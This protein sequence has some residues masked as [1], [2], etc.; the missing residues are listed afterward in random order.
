M[1]RALLVTFGLV[2]FAACGP[3]QAGE[4]VAP[5]SDFSTGRIMVKT[6]GIDRLCHVYQPQGKGRL[7]LVI[8]IH[9]STD[10]PATI[11]K[12]TGFDA[13]ARKEGFLLAVP[14]VA[15]PN[16]GWTSHP[17][18]FG[19]NGA[20]SDDLGFFRDLLGALEAAYS[21][22]PKRIYVA[23]HL[24]GGM[25]A[26]RIGADFAQQ[27][28]AIG[29]VNGTIG[30][31]ATTSG[32]TSKVPKPAVPVPLIAFHGWS[33]DVLPY[34]G[35]KS[36]RANRK[37][38]SVNESIDFWKK[39][40]GCTAKAVVERY[41]DRQTVRIQYPSKDGRSDVIL[42]KLPNNNHDWPAKVL[43][44]NGSAKTPAELMWKFF[45]AHSR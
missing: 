25:M 42:Y 9:C 18:I 14:E 2:P 7:P 35:G 3:S 23:G 20:P 27:V 43:S 41:G 10:T 6:G 24:S 39:V 5:V 36:P 29:V 15:G 33:N 17:S 1:F 19:K 37:F 40:N 4:P 26:Y 16:K 38:L 32:I 44:A 28:A 30:V 13:L 22:D 8:L 12:K 34:D 21:I 11:V 31:T 45:S